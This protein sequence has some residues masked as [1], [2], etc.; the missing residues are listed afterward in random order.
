MLFRK[1]WVTNWVKYF[2]VKYIK[3]QKREQNLK[4]NWILFSAF[5]GFYRITDPL[6]LTPVFSK[7]YLKNRYLIQLICTVCTKKVVV[8]ASFL[9]LKVFCFVYH[10]KPKE[11]HLVF[12]FLNG[13]GNRRFCWDTILQGYLKSSF[14]WGYILLQ[15]HGG[16]LAEKL[17]TR[18]VL[19]SAL[20]FTAILTLLTPLI[21][22]G[23][24]HKPCGQ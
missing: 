6:N 5:Q 20:F 3:P 11:V 13:D 22:E 15:I 21:A 17:G 23:G 7:R 19:G 10:L 14:F 24:I 18:L 8:K 4:S 12:S 16:T 9:S 2:S 1:N